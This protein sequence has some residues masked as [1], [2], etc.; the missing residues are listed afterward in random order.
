MATNFDT[1]LT[2]FTGYEFFYKRTVPSGRSVGD[3]CRFVLAQL[4]HDPGHVSIGN[5]QEL[6]K[7]VR[8]GY[9]DGNS[10]SQIGR[11][12][13][14][15]NIFFE[16]Q[17]NHAVDSDAY[18]IYF[19]NAN[20]A[21][22]PM[23]AGIMI[24]DDFDNSSLGA[25]WYSKAFNS[26][27][28]AET[29]F[30]NVEAPANGDV[31][32]F[33]HNGALASN[34]LS[35]VKLSKQDGTAGTQGVGAF[36]IWQLATDPAGWTDIADF[37]S[38]TG[39]NL[40][41]DRR[42]R[43]TIQYS[44]GYYAIFV[45]KWT[46]GVG[47]AATYDFA[48]EDWTGGLYRIENA[49]DEIR[50]TVE[51]SGST[52][53][54]WIWQ[55]DKL[56]TRLPI[57]ATDVYD[58][59]SNP[60]YEQHGATWNNN[61]HCHF[62]YSNGQ[63]IGSL[64]TLCTG[65]L[66]KYQKVNLEDTTLLGNDID[67]EDLTTLLY[68]QSLEAGAGR[69]AGIAFTATE[70]NYVSKI[71][72]K[73]KQANVA[74]T[75]AKYH[76][77]GE[78]WSVSGGVPQTLLG[79]CRR[80]SLDVEKS[81][82]T[83][84]DKEFYFPCPA[85]V[86]LNDELMF[87]Q[88]VYGGNGTSGIYVYAQSVG[89][90][91]TMARR[92]RA[93][94]IWGAW[95]VFTTKIGSI[96]VYYGKP[97]IVGQVYS[98]GS[99]DVANPI[100]E[101]GSLG[102][103]ADIVTPYDSCILMLCQAIWD[104]SQFVVPYNA[105]TID[106]NSWALDTLERNLGISTGGALTSLSKVN[107]DVLIP[108]ASGTHINQDMNIYDL[109]PHEYKAY[110]RSFYT[111]PVGIK[112]RHLRHMSSTD[113]L[114][115]KNNA[116]GGWV[117][118]GEVTYPWPDCTHVQWPHVWLDGGT[119]YIMAMYR[120]STTVPEG[121]RFVPMVA[122]K[123]TNTTLKNAYAMYVDMTDIV[124]TP[125]Y[126]GWQGARQLYEDTKGVG[127]HSLF[128]VQREVDEA[129]GNYVYDMWGFTTG[130]KKIFG[131]P[132]IIKER[133]S[134]Y[135]NADLGFIAPIMVDDEIVV[136]S[137][138]RN[139]CLSG[140]G[141]NACEAA[142][143]P[144]TNDVGNLASVVL[145]VPVPIITPPDRGHEAFNDL[146]GY[147]H[148]LAGTIPICNQDDLLC[149]DMQSLINTNNGVGLINDGYVKDDDDYSDLR[150]AYESGGTWTD[151]ARQ[152]IASHINN[153]YIAFKA[154]ANHALEV[155]DKYITYFGNSQPAGSLFELTEVTNDDLDNSSFDTT[156]LW[157]YEDGGTVTETDKLLAASAA[158]GEVACWG[159]KG[160][161]S[162]FMRGAV[163][164]RANVNTNNHMTLFSI[165][166]SS[167]DPQT[168]DATEFDNDSFM[169]AA[170]RFRITLVYQA[171][172]T[173][174]MYIVYLDDTDTNRLWDFAGE[175]WSTSNVYKEFTGSA[176][177][178]YF[179]VIAN[180][181]GSDWSVKVYNE[182][183]DTLVAE[184][185]ITDMKD[186][187]ED[188]YHLAGDWR[189]AFWY[190]Q[191]EYTHFSMFN[192]LEA[193]KE[194]TKQNRPYDD[195]LSVYY[196]NDV[197]AFKLGCWGA[198][199]SDGRMGGIVITLPA[200]IYSKLAFK[201]IQGTAFNI[202]IP[203]NGLVYVEVFSV[204][205]SPTNLLTRAKKCA[206]G[207]EEN[208]NSYQYL[209]FELPSP[210][211]LTGVTTLGFFLIVKGDGGGAAP[212][213]YLALGEESVGSGGNAWYRNRT[214][215][216]WQ[217]WT[218]IPTRNM[219]FKIWNGNYGVLG[220]RPVS[221]VSRDGPILVADNT[222]S[223]EHDIEDGDDAEHIYISQV[224]E[225]GSN[226]LI[227][228]SSYD[229][230]WAVGLVSRS[231]GAGIATQ[232]DLSDITKYD[233]DPLLIHEDIGLGTEIS[234]HHGLF[235]YDNTPGARKAYYRAK[236]KTPL[237]GGK[238]RHIRHTSNAHANWNQPESGG[239][240]GPD[241]VVTYP[242]PICRDIFSPEPYEDGG[243]VFVVA[244]YDFNGSDSYLAGI[245]K[246]LI[247]E[248]STDT[249]WK[250][251]RPIFLDDSD[252]GGQTITGIFGV[253]GRIQTSDNYYHGMVVVQR[254][255]EPPAGGNTHY[256]EAYVVSSLD[257]FVW[258]SPYKILGIGSAGTEDEMGAGTAFIF[259]DNK[260]VYTAVR[261]YESPPVT[262]PYYRV[263]ANIATIQT[264][265]LL[266]GGSSPL[267]SNIFE[268]NI[269]GGLICG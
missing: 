189:G 199:Q 107:Q 12:I 99:N 177:C 201:L 158:A 16:A 249:T 268:S 66:T 97:K 166:Q 211:V 45:T 147:N 140:T 70:S 219:G 145:T 48:N 142:G 175:E 238:D 43:I 129:D 134:G 31:A 110:Y 126:S 51:K 83:I 260:L 77:V 93:N 204:S 188:Y 18:V 94:G 259:G 151:I 198:D 72:V 82:E 262:P 136:Y 29:S 255:L 157:K 55:N 3:T 115:T 1:V 230:D 210:V 168:W 261:K 187:T 184:F 34:F 78:L 102:W 87:V 223:W 221:L 232:D 215:G 209:E 2:T 112:E 208:G 10:W 226:K 159:N 131:S 80:S 214:G 138:V 235:I 174:R 24:D 150:I 251:A 266:V 155:A 163:T 212:T 111:T 200:G 117:T 191:M 68:Y 118:D 264:L 11:D 269:F 239:G 62:H 195:N 132:Y 217:S 176:T 100:L 130:D 101:S 246:I 20:E 36:T 56:I 245:S 229:D 153:S 233:Q 146:L 133:D 179:Q 253:Y 231:A 237:V 182:N 203:D 4:L 139:Y 74:E 52:W 243:T 59:G 19:G 67:Y 173:Y 30:L 250:N 247:G 37:H 64:G 116:D 128:S 41:N 27:D 254:P 135:V 148:L 21:T 8:V 6:F 234:G 26:G 244:T 86:D 183:D 42:I 207:I 248:R 170:H 178:P 54:I 25:D 192:G 206:L 196:E 228:Y 222:P 127:F 35:S 88:R 90:G 65:V 7:D 95:S 186:D 236:Y 263:Q 252:F 53:R 241:G 122:E 9:Y 161:I 216:V 96:K 154:Q 141:R 40:S 165:F 22:T 156:K 218:N 160:A 119:T 92:T 79:R 69:E 190:G 267:F 50:F 194:E 61:H 172:N 124:Q 123:D 73:L 205:G 39:K 144:Y 197:E 103:E 185:T 14:G 171:A 5:C 225:D 137:G 227:L 60:Y 91:G 180:R 47:G 44:G 120:R 240:W 256:Y 89:S 193:T 63:Y 17:A 98:F 257:G 181:D 46:D 13:I 58:D 162:S 23:S 164:V 109:T 121:Y 258:G 15:N 38:S 202:Q 114:V 75:D 106:N 224:L 143:A 57:E 71:V 108:L 84:Q 167:T 125:G 76:M 104:G 152:V 49:T 81:T 105:D 169:L 85:Y 113:V 28:V 32:C 242:W 220:D 213:Q 149:I 33:G 265:E